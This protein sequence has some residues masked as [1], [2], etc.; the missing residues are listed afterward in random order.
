MLCIWEHV[1]LFC[2]AIISWFG[3]IT[4][5]HHFVFQVLGEN[6]GYNLRSTEGVKCFMAWFRDLLFAKYFVSWLMGIS[7]HGHLWDLSKQLLSL[8][9]ASNPYF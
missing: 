9:A 7:F 2:K 8:E 4:M 3:I 1:K 6:N 5:N